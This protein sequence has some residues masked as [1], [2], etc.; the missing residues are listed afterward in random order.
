M[1]KKLLK[2]RKDMFFEKGTVDWGL[3]EALAFG[4]LLTE[5]FTI[6][7]SG[8]DCQRGTFSH[9]HSV[10]RDEQ[11]EKEYIPLNNIE[12][13][14]AVWDAASADERFLLISRPEKYTLP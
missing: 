9:R 10:I 12:E 14:Q 7:L 4:T 1:K 3:A 6:R 2:Q 13:G 11:D 8:E 5:D